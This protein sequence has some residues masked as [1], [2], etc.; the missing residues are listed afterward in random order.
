[1]RSLFAVVALAASI[2]AQDGLL[3]S[4]LDN[5]WS[6]TRSTPTTN[7]LYGS[8][9]YKPK[10][11]APLVH[12]KPWDQCERDIEDTE[13]DIV[14][15]QTEC[16]AAVPG[17][18]SAMVSLMNLMTQVNA[19]SGQKDGNSDSIASIAETNRDQDDIL[20]MQQSD[21]ANAKSEVSSVVLEAAELQYKIDHLPDVASLIMRLE[22][23]EA[24]QTNLQNDITANDTDIA[25]VNSILNIANPANAGPGLIT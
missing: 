16:K 6:S 11:R 25:D 4:G 13:Q 19:L 2:Q 8:Y 9:N 5:L 12:E 22:A 20:T 15:T 3:G 18:S 7:S 14:R 24:R 23:I 10:T 1:M 21:L 17:I